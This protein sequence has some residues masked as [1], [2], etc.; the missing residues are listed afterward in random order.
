[1]TKTMNDLVNFPHDIT[2]DD[3]TGELVLLKN[4]KPTL[5]E[6]HGIYD[7]VARFSTQADLDKYLEENNLGASNE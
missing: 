3:E 7:E 2:M 6:S 5:E 1:M 4:T